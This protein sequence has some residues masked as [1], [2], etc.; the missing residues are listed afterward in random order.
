MAKWSPLTGIDISPVETVAKS[1]DDATTV[2]ADF[3]TAVAAALRVI[4]MFLFPDVDIINAILNAVIDTIEAMILDLLSNN[5]AIAF[6]VNMHW[7]QE[8]MWDRSSLPPNERGGVPNWT[9]DRDLP[10]SANGLDG[11]LLDVAASAKNEADPFRPLTDEDTMVGGF[12][13]VLGIPSFD[14]IGDIV[15]LFEALVDFSDAK[16]IMDEARLD[17]A[18]RDRAFMRAKAALYSQALAAWH[19]DPLIAKHDIQEAFGDVVGDWSFKPGSFPKWLSVPLA[20]IFPP[21]HDL[22][23]RLRDVVDALRIPTDNP[24]AELAELLAQKAEIL[25]ALAIEINDIIQ[26]LLA[27]AVLLEG[28]YFTWIKVPVDG[29]PEG[30][31]GGMDTFI[32]E[33]IAAD[34]KPR[35]GSGAIFGGIVGVVTLDN[36]LSHLESFFGLLGVM[37]T[38]YGDTAT[39]RY[40]QVEDTI[41]EVTS[42]F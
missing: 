41:D 25:A 39:T 27:L 1:I 30:T 8:W 10:W 34:D 2:I 3:L 7:N 14:N 9:E 12:I 38:E 26:Q 19:L 6:H 4:A 24:L 17:A 15:K 16:E 36:P 13:Y 18:D 28:G 20:R 29:A 35:L 31:G 5:V 37:M 33:A 40:G 21:I 23:E 32:A 11:W 42:F 22:L